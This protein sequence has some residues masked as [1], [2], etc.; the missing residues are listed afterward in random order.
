[1]KYNQVL[2]V[3]ITKQV[4]IN[5]T[6]SCINNYIINNI[7]RCCTTMNTAVTKFYSCAY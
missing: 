4:I 3:M 2:H 1:M 7:H 5:V 6:T